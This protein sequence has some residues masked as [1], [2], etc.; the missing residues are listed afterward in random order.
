[1]TT[2]H[3]AVLARHLGGRL[4][5]GNLWTAKIRNF[6]GSAETS[7]VCFVPPSVRKSARPGRGTGAESVDTSAL[8]AGFAPAESVDTSSEMAEYEVQ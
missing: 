7:K 5:T 3:L 8:V 4:R 1:M 2:I 6:S